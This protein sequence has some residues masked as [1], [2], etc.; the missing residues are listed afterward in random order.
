MTMSNPIAA[1]A[2][3]L[4][5]FPSA[6]KRSFEDFCVDSF[7]SVATPSSD[8]DEEDSICD[9]SDEEREENSMVQS[10]VAAA[11]AQP[12]GG[13]AR[14]LDQQL[15]RGAKRQRMTE[16]HKPRHLGIH[17]E[18]AP[19]LNFANLESK[20]VTQQTANVDFERCN[21]D[22]RLQSML[23]RHGV[24]YKTEPSLSLTN[25]FTKPSESYDLSLIQ[26]V[27]NQD[28]DTLRLKMNLGQT[29]Q[30]ANTF[31]HTLL[32]TA[33]RRGATEIV[34]FFLTEA[35]DVTPKVVCDM[36]RTPLHDACWTA[37]PNFCIIEMLLDASPD[38]LFL[39]DKRGFTP[40]AYV[41]KEH[42]PDWCVFL[43]QR[44]VDK[45]RPSEIF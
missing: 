34:R 3:L 18:S 7:H 32:H 6:Y 10:I 44:G 40:M 21:P 43:E 12:K 16:Q 1:A 35:N 23:R 5:D 29:M 13:L 14:L 15:V 28:I 37:Q 26:A 45:L 41:P 39:T 24:S 38:L 33:A 25:F 20:P 27:R 8:D 31:G 2:S 19:E 9:D 22:Q 42:W 30:C 36:G 4:A 11:M 17:S